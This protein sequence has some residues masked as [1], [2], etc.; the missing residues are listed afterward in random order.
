MCPTGSPD[1]CNWQ[2]IV[3]AFGLALKSACFPFHFRMRTHRIITEHCLGDEIVTLQFNETD[4]I[5]V[6]HVWA[7]V[8]V[9]A[10]VYHPT[11]TVIDAL[12][13]K[14]SPFWDKDPAT[15]WKTKQHTPQ[16]Q[17]SPSDAMSPQATADASL[18]SDPKH[19]CDCGTASFAFS[20]PT[21]PDLPSATPGMTLSFIHKNSPTVRWK[22]HRCGKCVNGWGWF[23]IITVHMEV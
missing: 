21:G 14:V 1:S 11:L 19:F 3:K 22:C 7:H 13:L 16:Q 10:C 12:C 15:C 2:R 17:V 8:C 20:P 18:T 4:V 9:R 6:T 5:N 23:R